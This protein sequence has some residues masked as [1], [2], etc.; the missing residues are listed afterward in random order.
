[1]SWRFERQHYREKKHSTKSRILDRLSWHSC[2]SCES[3]TLATR[4]IHHVRI[5]FSLTMQIVN[6][7]L[8][9]LIEYYYFMSANEICFECLSMSGQYFHW[10]D[11]HFMWALSFVGFDCKE[12]GSLKF[13]HRHDFDSHY[14]LHFSLARNFNITMDS[15]WQSPF[16]CCF[17]KRK[18]GKQPNTQMMMW[19]PWDN[20]II[21]TMNAFLFAL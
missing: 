9:T 8:Q 20:G 18:E 13:Q 5:H 4:C 21:R 3:P 15:L 14:K 10:N 16:V 19:K 6:V 7:Q 1:M 11:H 2:H 12:E 17:P